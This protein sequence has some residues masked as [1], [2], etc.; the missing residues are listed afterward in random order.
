ME[1]GMIEDTVIEAAYKHASGI[2]Q[3]SCNGVS[4]IPLY[5]KIFKAGVL[6]SRKNDVSVFGIKDDKPDVY[7]SNNGYI[8]KLYFN[9]QKHHHIFQIMEA[10]SANYART[11]IFG[12]NRDYENCQE[13]AK[14][15]IKLLEDGLSVDFIKELI[16]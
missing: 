10:D 15:I 11:E 16:K 3:H 4:L 8:L 1:S 5:E 2:D 6:W 9:N 13:V 12:T 7:Y 14:V